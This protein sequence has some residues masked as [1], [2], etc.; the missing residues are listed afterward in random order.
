MGYTPLSDAKRLN[1]GV[2]VW[3]VKLERSDKE[4]Y[5]PDHPLS[6]AMSMGIS[7]LHEII[8]EI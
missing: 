6:L 8:H 7:T 4:I 1:L 2:F 5:E 3:W